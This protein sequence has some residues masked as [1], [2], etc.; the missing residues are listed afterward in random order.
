MLGAFALA[1][2]PICSSQIVYFGL[3]CLIA[4][5]ISLLN[6]IYIVFFEGK[7]SLI[8]FSQFL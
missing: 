1:M 7:V 2:E 4:A 8:Y 5:L 6:F 3:G